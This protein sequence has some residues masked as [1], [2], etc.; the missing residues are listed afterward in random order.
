[1]KPTPMAAA[2]GVTWCSTKGIIDRIR[3]CL[4]HGIRAVHVA[5]PFWMPVNA[6]DMD[7]FWNDLA[8]AAP[9][10]RWIHYNVSRVNRMLE[11]AD[12]VRLS[13]QYPEQL[14]GTKMGTM[15]ILG[16]A[17][18]ITSTPQLAHLTVDYATVP[19]M[20]LGGKGVCSY[21]VNTMPSW[22]RRL[23]DLCLERQWEAAMTMQKQL[24]VWE[25]NYVKPLR[26]AGHLHGV[27]GKARGALSGFLEDNRVT[28][29][30]Y[31]PV[32]DELFAQFKKDFEKYWRE[33]CEPSDLS[34]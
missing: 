15:D 18:C 14:I 16:L 34:S 20:M 28:R 22:T 21:W 5:F 26:Q 33:R 23:F 9:E 11:G 30:P 19:V 27:I 24:L 25:A 8:E 6:R 3:V 29:A 10:A 12:Y 31:Y 1:M 17:D 4:D 7:R 13:K 2:V 32:G